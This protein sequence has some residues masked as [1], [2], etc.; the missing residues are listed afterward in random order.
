MKESI[1]NINDKVMITSING[2]CK[3]G[4]VVSIKSLNEDTKYLV[5]LDDYPLR[6][7]FFKKTINI[8]K[9]L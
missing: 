6:I 8:H 4:T 7:W 3:F 2:P 9:I 1:I 5:A